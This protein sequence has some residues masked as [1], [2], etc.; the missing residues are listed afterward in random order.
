[1]RR[2]FNLLHKD[3]KTL[4]EVRFSTF[5]PQDDIIIFL[6]KKVLVFNKHGIPLTIALSD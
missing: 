6:R 4:N 3:E 1:M 2:A 5:T